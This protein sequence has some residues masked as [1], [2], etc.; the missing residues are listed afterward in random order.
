MEE[1]G[2]GDEGGCCCYGRVGMGYGRRGRVVE[3]WRR[4]WNEEEDKVEVETVVER[5]RMDAV[6]VWQVVAD[7]VAKLLI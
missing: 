6:E 5:C 4:G 2:G 1:N 7:A 3:L